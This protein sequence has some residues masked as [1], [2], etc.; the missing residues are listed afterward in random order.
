MTRAPDT[1]PPGAPHT[2]PAIRL[3]GP[4]DLLAVIPYLLGFHPT[5]SLVVVGL[6]EGR[7]AF[8]FRAD[9]ADPPAPHRIAA[10][11][12]AQSL[13]GV[14]IIGYGPAERVDPISEPV[15]AALADAG[16]PVLDRL[17]TEA[18]R[19]WSDSCR[20]SDCC[21]PDGQPL[22][23]PSRVAAEATLAGLVALPSRDALAAQ[24]APVTGPARVAM[25]RA[26]HR[27]ELRLQSLLDT[28]PTPA[29]AA[30][31]MLAD[32]LAAV[33]DAARRYGTD[34]AVRLTDDEVAW[35]GIVL[36]AT[37]VR[38]EAWLL[39][40]GDLAGHR[41][42][43]TDV[44]RRVT[45]EYLAAP[46]ALTGFVC[47]QQGDGAVGMMALG[48]ALAVDP[49][50]SMALLLAQA[51]AGGLPPTAWRPTPTSTSDGVDS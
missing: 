29:A 40:E 30:E 46:A 34:P 7:I 37:Q 19:F 11:L 1:T 24:L 51:L 23:V 36:A 13:T 16:R 22:G 38:D 43:W 32:G 3:A 25:E 27:A 2:A 49:S 6:R 12:S 41:A 26:T 10:M 47:W 39:A 17:R 48:R 5:D 31:R 14:I 50:Y 28:A 8:C 20:R 9:L 44:L 18:G 45:D 15:A 4:A 42:L 35:L 33:R 21:P